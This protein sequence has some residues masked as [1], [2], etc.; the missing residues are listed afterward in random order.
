MQL[1]LFL[2]IAVQSV[3]SI[4]HFF[5][6]LNVQV[7]I[8]HRMVTACSVARFYSTVINAEVLSVAVYVQSAIWFWAATVFHV[9][10]VLP[11]VCTVNQINVLTVNLVFLLIITNTVYHTVMFLTVWHVTAQIVV[12]VASARQATLLSEILARWWIVLPP[13]S[14]MEL[15][16]HVPLLFIT[17]FLQKNV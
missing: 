15:V 12:N 5:T 14:L 11:T 16:A 9:L 10:P 2:Q 6:A 4:I 8:M 13:I 3:T 1:T 7:D 17:K